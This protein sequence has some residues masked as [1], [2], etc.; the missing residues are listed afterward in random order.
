MK[1]FSAND[2]SVI[3]TFSHHSTSRAH[4]WKN[5]DVCS[6]FPKACRIVSERCTSVVAR[7]DELSS[8]VFVD[9]GTVKPNVPGLIY[10]EKR[11]FPT[12]KTG[13]H[14]AFRRLG[15]RPPIPKLL[16]SSLTPISSVLQEYPCS[17]AHFVREMLPRFLLL[18]NSQAA[19]LKFLVPS[20]VV[21]KLK[22]FIGSLS[23]NISFFQWEPGVTVSAPRVFFSAS[24]ATSRGE[25]R[26]F[27]NGARF[28]KKNFMGSCVSC[29]R[30][31][32]H[33]RLSWPVRPAVR[34]IAILQRKRA[35][36]S[37][38]NRA[39]VVATLRAAFPD[40]FI[41]EFESETHNLRRLHSQLSD[42]LVLL[43]PH[44][45]GLS[46]VFMLPDEAV[47]IEIGFTGKKQMAFP[48][49]YY[50]RWS[51]SCGL[52]HYVALGTGEY[53]SQ[54]RVNLT[55]LRLVASQAIRRAMENQLNKK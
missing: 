43:A 4:R 45:A 19:P 31:R 13:H 50:A 44:G 12:F 53:N 10:S 42:A 39:D 9:G 23:R 27:T 40:F 28:E 17:Y 8:F 35:Q 49:N 1:I 25:W 48:Q 20:C 26:R 51:A 46:N 5:D 24:Y 52:L 55:S 15:F 33:V 34:K 29:A 14:S 54:I 41:F 38:E 3:V 32:Q 7:V 37:L 11:I 18:L 36:R 22:S 2:T 6:V 21:S 16:S 30:V 47:V